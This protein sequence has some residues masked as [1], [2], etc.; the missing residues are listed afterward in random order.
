MTAL[1][2]IF[3][4]LLL[5]LGSLALIGWLWAMERYEED[6]RRERVKEGRRLR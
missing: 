3:A 2:L 1:L 6:S 5:S 4:G